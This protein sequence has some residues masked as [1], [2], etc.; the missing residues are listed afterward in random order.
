MLVE[1]MSRGYGVYHGP[2]ARL[3]LIIPFLMTKLSEGIMELEP[4]AA[5]RS[6]SSVGSSCTSDSSSSSLSSG[7]A[8]EM[9]LVFSNALHLAVEYGSVDVLRL[10][11]KYG[12]E[13]NQGGRV[14]GGLG[15]H[16]ATRPPIQP[17]TPTTTTSPTH[18]SITAVLKNG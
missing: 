14:A 10:L 16:P 11:L 15:D 8:G 1:Y 9:P 12:L 6:I 18:T 17:S 4:C 7:G 13:P 5:H 3:Y 2:L